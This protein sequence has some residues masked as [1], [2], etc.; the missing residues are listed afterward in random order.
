MIT[1]D[2]NWSQLITIDYNWLQLI[3]IKWLETKQSCEEGQYSTGWQL[4]RFE[5]DSTVPSRLQYVLL[6]CPWLWEFL[7]VLIQIKVKL[8]QA[9][10]PA[11]G[12]TPRHSEYVPKH[13]VVYPVVYPSTHNP[14]TTTT[15]PW[16][17]RKTWNTVSKNCYLI[18]ALCN[19]LS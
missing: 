15:S 17:M 11:T 4:E 12:I 6:N 1:A 14:A 5:R 8:I 9:W 13:T 18:L 3:T 10:P 19:P 16:W 7:R 2:Y